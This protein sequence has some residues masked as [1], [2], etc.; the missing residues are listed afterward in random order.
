VLE[1]A[2]GPIAYKGLSDE[3]VRRL[4]ERIV[5][6]ELKEGERI[7]ERN[8]AEELGL[9]RG[10]VRD[11]L[12]QLERDGLVELL[13]RRGARVAS[14]TREDV[15]E[16]IALRVAV[17]PVAIQIF[18][19][20]DHPEKFDLL[21]RCLEAMEAAANDKDW[22]A[23]TMAHT[24]FH[25]LI[26]TMPGRTRL[27]KIWDLLRVPIVQVFR[28]HR[29]LTSIF[30]SAPAM[31]RELFDA[32]RNGEVS[33]ATRLAQSHITMLEESL[34]ELASPAAHLTSVGERRR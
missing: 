6:G 8:V 23:A 28:Q 24:E 18:L 3:V 27:G 9:S 19:E 16:Y 1:D 10:P 26:Y 33:R 15:E 17:E 29:H 11:A 22:R 34:L 14:M 4:A 25:R 20:Y 7:T 30:D 5:F 21:E 2:T 12:R 13:P 31:H 32:L